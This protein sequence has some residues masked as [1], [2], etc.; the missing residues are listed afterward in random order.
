MCVAGGPAPG[1]EL[2]DRRRSG[3]DRSVPKGGLSLR[4]GG[5]KRGRG[6]FQK[7]VDS[8]SQEIG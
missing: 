8:V 6:E 7:R 4:F 3:R 1:G 5:E 2:R